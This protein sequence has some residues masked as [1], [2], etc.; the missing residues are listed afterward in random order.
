MNSV[1]ISVLILGSLGFLFGL[2]LAFL[3]K[4][5]KVQED[6]RAE[7]V[8]E[9]LP[10]LN[11]G[12]CGF[13]GCRAYAEAV[14]KEC[15][16]FS[17][18]LPG[19][20]KLNNQIS[21]VLGLVGCINDALE[22]VVCRCGA[23]ETEK[24]VSSYYQGPLTCRAADM[25]GGVIDCNYGCIGFRDCIEVCPVGALSLE[26]KKI[27]VNQNKCIGCQK[28]VK[29]C[30]RSLFEL[31]IPQKNS[32]IYYVSCNNKEKVLAVKAV[33][34]KGCIGCGICVKLED[35][36]Y[37]LKDNLSYIDYSKANEASLEA[38]K[39]KCPTKCIKK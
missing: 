8:L 2:L 17:G 26:K 32:A 35:S 34:Q 30:P 29:A 18:C 3:S 4:K 19:G 11:C 14:V 15:S 1:I 24:K 31:V 20:A 12:A 25:T 39:L 5:L 36:P 37:Y 23:D 27:E 22:V 21:Q 7:K 10:G 38:G 9:L 6:P 13:S 33:C 16:I 28:C